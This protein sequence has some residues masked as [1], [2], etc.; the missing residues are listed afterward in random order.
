MDYMK[1]KRDE[2]LA[3]NPGKKVPPEDVVRKWHGDAILYGD[4]KGGSI[5]S[6]DQFAWQADKAGNAWKAKPP[7]DQPEKTK[8]ALRALE[9]LP[10]P[11]PPPV[12]VDEE[13]PGEKIG[14]PGGVW[15]RVQGGWM[16]VR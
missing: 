9:A 16:R 7:E 2:W 3:A 15:K 11:A 13:V 14:K 8:A 1:G 5:F 12:P 6:S 4:E 10:K